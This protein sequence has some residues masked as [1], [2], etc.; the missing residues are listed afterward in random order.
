MKLF[1][2]FAGLALVNGG[3]NSADPV[4]QGLKNQR[5]EFLYSSAD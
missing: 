2:L 1:N 5:L 3:E 4:G